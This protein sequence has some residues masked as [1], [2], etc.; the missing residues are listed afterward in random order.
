MRVIQQS[1]NSGFRPIRFWVGGIVFF[2][3]V[4]GVALAWAAQ[5]STTDEYL[6][7]TLWALRQEVRELAEENRKLVER[8]R[9][10]RENIAHAKGELDI[11]AETKTALLEAK[12]EVLDYYSFGSSETA[13]WRRKLMN[14]E[15]TVTMLTKQKQRLL[16]ALRKEQQRWD[17]L[18]NEV[19]WVTNQI[20]EFNLE[21]KEADPD[22]RLIILKEEKK[23]MRQEMAG[24]QERYD[25]IEEQIPL[26][27][28]DL[29]A[30]DKEKQIYAEETRVL[31]QELSRS[32]KAL[33]DIRADI[34]GMRDRSVKLAEDK[35]NRIQQLND[36][37]E[38]YRSYRNELQDSFAGVREA[39]QIILSEAGEHERRL[40][41]IRQ[42]LNSKID[43]LQ[44][45]RLGL[46][47]ALALIQE[48]RTGLSEKLSLEGEIQKMN[49]KI[50]EMTQR[51]EEIRARMAEDKR[52]AR[53]L[54]TQRKELDGKIRQLTS[55]SRS[56]R[57]KAQRIQA[58]RIQ[59]KE[60]EMGRQVREQQQEVQDLENQIEAMIARVKGMTARLGPLADRQKSMR[61]ELASLNDEQK[62]LIRD[63]THLR[64][65]HEQI[66]ARES[67]IGDRLA[68][69]IEDL[70]LQRD[71]L[72]S[73]LSAVQARYMGEGAD[74][75]KEEVELKDYLR[76]LR[77]ENKSLQMR[78]LG[79]MR[80]LKH[81]G[82]D[83]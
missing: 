38:Q 72:L 66:A 17:I 68:T 52:I 22:Y 32:E 42:L 10:L 69:E 13:L 27:K 61:A 83:L 46:Q 2:Y 60:N 71:I 35:K 45:R 20:R 1:D 67:I 18:R 43:L 24:A 6:D 37:I 73:S 21:A 56:V 49:N 41:G 78:I 57:E 7:F 59:R 31:N 74:F 54:S 64:K 4:A 28:Q 30:F 15:Y 8:N 40:E 19:A 9:V 47:D 82:Q 5:P 29:K 26:L 53:D 70:K 62:K 79:L 3:L 44:Q 39:R 14:T 12:N 63:Q 65:L 48:I 50:I 23:R 16:D 33:E 80:R 55:Q 76:I 51:Q 11:L 75:E 81:D 58:T 34:Q 36:E 77:E 25:K